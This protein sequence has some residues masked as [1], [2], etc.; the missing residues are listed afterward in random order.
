M[1]P[2]SVFLIQEYNLLYSLSCAQIDTDEAGQ[3]LGKALQS[4]MKLRELQSVLISKFE[5]DAHLFE[6]TTVISV[7]IT[8]F[9]NLHI[10]FRTSLPKSFCKINVFLQLFY[11]PLSSF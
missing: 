7:V 1:T 6:L 11:Q 4:M 3:A 9:F 8:C 2:S 10:L 5:F